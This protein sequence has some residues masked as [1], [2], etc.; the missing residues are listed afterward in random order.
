MQ[1]ESALPT[2]CKVRGVRVANVR[3]TLFKLNCERC[4]LQVG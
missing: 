1:M 3:L 2:S 4:K